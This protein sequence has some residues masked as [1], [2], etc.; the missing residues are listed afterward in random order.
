M[1]EHLRRKNEGSK[2][3]SNIESKYPNS[4]L[5]R[6]RCTPVDPPKMRWL[7]GE[8]PD[9]HTLG[10]YLPTGKRKLCIIFEL[11]EKNN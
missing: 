5:K 9:I 2:E 3:K 7:F 6:S 1:R 11:A 4:I 10:Y 8:N